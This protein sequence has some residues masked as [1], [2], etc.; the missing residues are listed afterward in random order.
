VP[1]LSKKKKK[2]GTQT[3]STAQLTKIRQFPLSKTEELKFR[4]ER[5]SFANGLLWVTA[6]SVQQFSHVNREAT[7]NRLIF[8]LSI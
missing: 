6:L 4:F 3:F 5:T 7:V 8:C 2:I 1:K